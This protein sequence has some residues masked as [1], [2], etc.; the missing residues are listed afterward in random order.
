MK[1]SSRSIPLQ[2]LD[3]YSLADSKPIYHFLQKHSSGYEFA[4]CI[5]AYAESSSLETIW[6]NFP[7][8]NTPESASPK[9]P[10]LILILLNHPTTATAEALQKNQ[11][12]QSAILNLGQSIATKSFTS[13]DI[14]LNLHLIIPQ[15]RQDLH[16]CL[17]HSLKPYSPKQGIGKARRVL[18]DTAAHLYYNDL[19]SNPWFGMTDADARLPA[20][21]IQA[22][23]ELKVSNTS[24]GL[25]LFPFQHQIFSNESQKTQQLLKLHRLYEAYLEDYRHHLEMAFAEYAHTPL[26]SI[27]AIHCHAYTHVRGF[28]LKAAGEDFYLMNKM[29]KMFKVFQ[30]CSQPILLETRF[31]ERTPFGTGQSV[32]KLSQETHIHQLP[33]FYNEEVLQQWILLLRNIKHAVSTQEWHEI[34][35]LY[36]MLLEFPWFN[37]LIQESQKAKTPEQ[38][39]HILLHNIDGL[40]CQQLLRLLHDGIPRSTAEQRWFTL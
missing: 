20:E 32:L 38:K 22:L 39:N 13:T 4:L 30:I 34:T 8:A 37:T 15:A 1:R 25:G 24:A 31:S 16:L 9:N 18:A 2:Y 6:Q 23:S 10:G 19:L 14:Q 33:L 26:G 21:Y 35:H 27:M 12:T 28:P 17:I 5:P 36:P 3:Q 29:I 11:Q 7:L 40:R